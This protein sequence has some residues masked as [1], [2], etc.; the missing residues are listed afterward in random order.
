MNRGDLYIAAPPGDYGK[1]RPV[2]IV[3]ND[4]IGELEARIICPLTTFEEPVVILRPRIE[5]TASNGLKRPSFIMVEKIIT[6]PKW[7]FRE[8]IGELDPANLAIVDIRL[9]LVLGLV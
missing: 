9:A 5:P 1:P 2:L 6:V 3:Q 8:R 7:R 4:A